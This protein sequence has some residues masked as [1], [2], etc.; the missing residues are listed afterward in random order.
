MIN[1]QVSKQVIRWPVTTTT[2]NNLFIEGE[3]SREYVE[4]EV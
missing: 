3:I 1:W 2:L 4:G